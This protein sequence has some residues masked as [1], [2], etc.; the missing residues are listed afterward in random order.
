MPDIDPDLTI[1]LFD[2]MRE[3]D[4]RL[5][6]AA[7]LLGLVAVLWREPKPE[8]E[9]KPIALGP[10]GQPRK[11]RGK[12]K[13]PKHADG[14]DSSPSSADSTESGEVTAPEPG[15]PPIPAP[16]LGVAVLQKADALARFK[17][18][19]FPAGS[20]WT[21]LNGGKILAKITVD[22]T[23]WER[24]D[25]AGKR[26]ALVLALRGLRH[27]TRV[28]DSADLAVIE[29]PPVH[30]WPDTTG[31][32]AELMAA[33]APEGAPGAELTGCL[34]AGDIGDQLL[35]SVAAFRRRVDAGQKLGGYLSLL[36]DAAEDLEAVISR[37]RAAHLAAE[38]DPTT[39]EGEDA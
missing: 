26:A 11:P 19:T 27:K 25:D 15:P 3:G 22:G 4:P 7:K 16:W 32:A 39:D 31:E 34:V 8:P 37:V 13:P 12:K 1:E 21:K 35:E 24:L 10:D 30:T 6:S 14:S 5:L 17:D 23:M 18:D 20:E 36:F 9:P 38:P 2:L 28:A 29:K 33:L